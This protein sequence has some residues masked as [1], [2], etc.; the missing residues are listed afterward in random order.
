MQV[1]VPGTTYDL[2][3]K[4]WINMELFDSWLD[5]NFLKHSVPGSTSSTAIIA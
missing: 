4:G 3:D 2:S 5:E 1:E